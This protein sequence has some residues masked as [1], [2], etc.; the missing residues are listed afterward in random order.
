MWTHKK[1]MQECQPAGS[2]TKINLTPARDS[3]SCRPAVQAE[4]KPLLLLM[5]K[6]LNRRTT[7]ALSYQ[8]PTQHSARKPLAALTSRA[9]GS[10]QEGL[11]G[12]SGGRT[13]DLAESGVPLRPS[14]TPRCDSKPLWKLSCNGSATCSHGWT[15]HSLGNVPESRKGR[16]RGDNNVLRYAKQC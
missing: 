1:C 2:K 4:T 9:H 16:S 12:G 14:A 3:L 7:A 6:Q 13:G 5:F 8:Y 10:R 11:G 15:E